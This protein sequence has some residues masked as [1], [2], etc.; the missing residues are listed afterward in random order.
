MPSI[1]NMVLFVSSN[2]KNCVEPLT[3]IQQTKIPVG[4]V[5]LDTKAERQRALNG[6]F[7]Q[8]QSVP[9]LVVFYD[10]GDMQMFLGREKIIGWFVTLLNKKQESE[11]TQ[12]LME[13]EP[14]PILKKGSKKRKGK[15]KVRFEEDL[16]FIDDVKEEPRQSGLI[17]G[18]SAVAPSGMN[19][20]KKKAEELKAQMMSTH[21][22]YGKDYEEK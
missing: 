7:F 2:S 15:K 3:F 10:D 11:H 13:E 20:I 4:V 22:R 18:P 8:I 21:K 9:S 1:Q 12:I 16:E 5:R 14:K 19:D 17:V 6:K